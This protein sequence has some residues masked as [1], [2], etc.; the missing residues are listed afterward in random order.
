MSERCAACLGVKSAGVA[1]EQR[2]PCYAAKD[3]H[4]QQGRHIPLASTV[5]AQ[6][7]QNGQAQT[8]CRM[9]RIQQIKTADRHAAKIVS[10]HNPLKR[11]VD[12][13]GFLQFALIKCLLF[14]KLS[15]GIVLVAISQSEG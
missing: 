6:A 11:S 9:H 12:E 10:V 15:A 1:H 3:R 13:Q 5:N 14:E 2:F 7:V 8:A 4:R